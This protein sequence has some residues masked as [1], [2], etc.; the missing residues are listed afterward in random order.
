MSD[1]PRDYR[2]RFDTA[3]ELQTQVC[4]ARSILERTAA[5]IAATEPY[6]RSPR[7]EL[8]K[9]KHVL[10]AAELLFGTETTPRF[11]AGDSKPVFISHSSRD[12]EFVREI[13][14]SLER[15]NI[16]CFVADRSIRT[17]TKWVEELWQALEASRVVVIV[18]T[19]RGL[20]SKWVMAESGAAISQKKVVVPVLRY[21]EQSAIPPHLQQFQSITVETDEQRKRLVSFLKRVSK[22]RGPGKAT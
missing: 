2:V 13:A 8:F 21:L 22:K 5:D 10:Q 7:R 14:D 3:N 4:R 1:L 12:K 18:L 17:A 20:K 19:P 11:S 15:S 9:R 16:G 6:R